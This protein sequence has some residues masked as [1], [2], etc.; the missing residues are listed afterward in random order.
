MWVLGVIDAVPTFLR[1]SP[2][3]LFAVFVLTLMCLL[4]KLIDRI[5]NLKRLAAHG[6]FT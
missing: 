4:Q 1:T 2:S 6:T 5:C 3:L